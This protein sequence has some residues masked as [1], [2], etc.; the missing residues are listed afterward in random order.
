M[1]LKKYYKSLLISIGAI[2]FL[3]LIITLLNYIG[4]INLKFI[5][6]FKYFVPFLAM[7][8]GGFILGKNSNNKGWLEGIKLGLMVILI[9]FAIIM[10]FYD[11]NINQLINYFIILAGS[12]LG[13]I[14]GINKKVTK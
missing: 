8:I 4:F 3:T 10:I 13:S 2:I 11:L 14:F 6:I 1:F 5:N 9:L 12:I 7:F